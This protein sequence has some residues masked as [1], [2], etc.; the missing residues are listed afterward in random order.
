MARR[1]GSS[2]CAIIPGGP[3]IR[4]NIMRVRR[5]FFGMLAALTG[6]A[7]DY[8]ADVPTAIPQG[9]PPTLI[10]FSTLPVAASTT[11]T[12]FDGPLAV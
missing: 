1:K 10:R 3:Q 5:D 2:L 9:S 8:F 12:S 11:D 4:Q 7:H 6:A